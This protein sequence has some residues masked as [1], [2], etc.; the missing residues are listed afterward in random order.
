MDRQIFIDL[1]RLKRW[2][3]IQGGKR[4]VDMMGLDGE[5]IIR[6]H[7]PAVGYV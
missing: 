1:Q 3:D 5:G 7:V 4:M 2:K 6:A